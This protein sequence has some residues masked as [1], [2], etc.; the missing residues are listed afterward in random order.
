MG[1]L[2]QYEAHQVR[3]AEYNNLPRARINTCRALTFADKLPP[4]RLDARPG[5]S[6]ADYPID[7]CLPKNQLRTPAKA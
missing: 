6:S 4:N 2:A 7:Y 1:L 3:A 5:R